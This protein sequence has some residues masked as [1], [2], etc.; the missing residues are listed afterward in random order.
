MFDCKKIKVKYTNSSTMIDTEKDNSAARLELRN[1][2]IRTAS[3]AFRSNG[4]KCITMDEIAASLSMSKRTL[5]E[6]FEDKETL[7]RECILADH[8]ELIAFI[9]EVMKEAKNVLEVILVCYKKNIERFHETNKQF[10][11]DIKKYPR[12]Y[13]LIKEFKTRDTDSTIAFL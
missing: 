8:D 13:D 12:V 6:I 7:L 4:I 5:Y 1:K 9:G 2:I 11:E 10:F 3:Q